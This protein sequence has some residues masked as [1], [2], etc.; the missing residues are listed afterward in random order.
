MKS[1]FSRVGELKL[2][3]LIWGKLSAERRLGEGDGSRGRGGKRER[4]AKERMVE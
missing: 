1:G 2:K 3:L 4:T